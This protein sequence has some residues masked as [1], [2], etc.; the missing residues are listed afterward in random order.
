M[1]NRRPN[2]LLHCFYQN[3]YNACEKSIPRITKRWLD[4]PSYMSSHSV[5]IKNKLKTLRKT[6]KRTEETRNLVVE[7]NLFLLKDKQNFIE[8]F[9]ISAN[10]DEYKFL[11]R[12][13]P[14]PTFPEKMKYRSQDIM[15]SQPI[16]ETFNEYF[17]S[18]FIEDNFDIVPA[19]AQPEI[20]LDD[21][22]FS[23]KD[24]L[25]EMLQIKSGA[26]SYD[27]ITPSLL[28]T[29]APYVLNSILYIFSCIINACQF[30]IVWKNIHARPIHK[31]GSQTENKNYRPIATL[32]AVSIV[33]QRIVYKQI[34]KTFERKL[35]TAR[36]VFRQKHST[37]TQLLLYCDNLYPALDKNS[38]PITV[39]LDI[40]KAFDTINFNN[41]LQ[42]LTRFGFEEKFLKFIASYLVD[43]QQRVK[44][45]DGYLKFWKISSE[46]PQG[47]IFAVFMFS[48][49]INDLPDQLND[50]TFLYADD[51]KII[52]QISEQE[53]LQFDLN[54]A[55]EWSGS[56][57]L[58]FNFDKF[59][60]LEF[61][62]KNTYN[63]STE[64]F[65]KG[66]AIKNKKQI[67]DLGLIFTVSMSLNCRLEM[68][69]KKG[70]LKL[71]YIRR[72][73]PR[74]T[75]Q[76][77]KCTLVKTYIFSAVFYA[78]NIWNPGTQYLQRLE[79]LQRSCLKWTT[80]R[81]V[82]DDKEYVESLIRNCL[83]PVSYFP[84]R[85]N[86]NLLNKILV[87]LI[88][89]NASDHW[90]E[91][92]GCPNTRSSEKLFIE[93]RKPFRKCSEDNYFNRVAQFNNSLSQLNSFANYSPHK[94]PCQFRRD[95]KI[96]LEVE[97]L[98]RFKYKSYTSGWIVFEKF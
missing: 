9:C 51:K 22:T 91:T 5:H 71:N 25:D 1:S 54:R 53:K 83:L 89:K 35:C 85:K 67:K 4:A 21:I 72:V 13:N 40:A 58:N 97:A 79:R 30:P 39:Y 68:A 80:C 61:S 48:V 19:T 18:I 94:N 65:A 31:N 14:E 38:S 70:F 62:Y 98:K 81:S 90:S 66:N 76:T 43:R 92:F 16:A 95:V 36:H 41:V 55:I 46:G 84:V 50:K 26:N 7:L 8:G 82:L 3:F 52:G 47:S 37:V 34:K 28:K 33:F 11:R 44:I 56:N 29:S 74:T 60:I 15:S 23:A 86:L 64:L 42:K 88:S 78:S 20:F 77:V 96:F 12:L 6:N 75:K 49:Y 59:S 17:S 63:S 69:V 45:A 93:A 10:N 27:Q 87:V 73:I 57:K 32:C 2:D 24:V